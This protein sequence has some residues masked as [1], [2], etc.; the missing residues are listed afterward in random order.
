MKFLDQGFQKLEPDRQTNT[1]ADANERITTPYSWLVV[2]K[3]NDYSL[4]NTKR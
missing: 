3:I 4:A 1:P 2:V